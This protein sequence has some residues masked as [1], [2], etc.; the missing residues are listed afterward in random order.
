[1]EDVT[2]KPAAF[3]GSAN[4][5]TTKKPSPS[6]IKLQ[7]MLHSAMPAMRRQLQHRDQRDG[8]SLAKKR[9]SR[10]H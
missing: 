7:E 1:L 10:P 9:Y 6:K 3:N 4:R 2:E 5:V 8:R